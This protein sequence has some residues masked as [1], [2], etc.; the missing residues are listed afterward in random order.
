MPSRNFEVLDDGGRSGWP[1]GL[2]AWRLLV[3]EGTRPDQAAAV[4]KLLDRVNDWL[5]SDSKLGTGYRLERSRYR[6][7]PTP[8]VEQLSKARSGKIIESI[9]SSYAEGGM[10][11]DEP[12][13]FLRDIGAK[14][15]PAPEMSA[16]GSREVVPVAVAISLPRIVGG[17]ARAAGTASSPPAAGRPRRL[18]HRGGEVESQAADAGRD[19]QRIH[20]A[21]PASTHPGNRTKAAA[22]RS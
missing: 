6:H 20:G 11:A 19:A 3:E 16:S 8:I 1:T 14:P 12:R 7:V 10:N 5:E 21:A 17:F 2:A 22:R 15:A 9:L 18:A 13:I 4:A